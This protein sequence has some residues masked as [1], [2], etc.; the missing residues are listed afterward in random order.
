MKDR[1][2]SK[3]QGYKN[4]LKAKPVFMSQETNNKLNDSEQ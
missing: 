3:G 1:T 2:N 4:S